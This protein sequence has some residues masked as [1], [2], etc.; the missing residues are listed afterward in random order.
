MID[1][2]ISS[3]ENHFFVDMRGMSWGIM[4]V[5]L[6][7]ELE[8]G[9]SLARM[10]NDKVRNTLKY[11]GRVVTACELKDVAKRA[12]AGLRPVV[13]AHFTNKR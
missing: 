8:G 2:R 10:M 4:F 6:K 5:F 12:L 3:D 9:A 13:E 7:H 11:S 1:P